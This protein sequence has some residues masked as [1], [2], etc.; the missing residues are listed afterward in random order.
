[1]EAW[2]FDELQKVVVSVEHLR[3]RRGVL[4]QQVTTVH[5]LMHR[6]PA[7]TTAL[8]DDLLFHT[9]AYATAVEGEAV[10]QFMMD[11]GARRSP[12]SFMYLLA[13]HQL[14]DEI[15]ALHN[16]GVQHLDQ[17]YHTYV[18]GNFIRLIR[19]MHLE[20]VECVRRFYVLCEKVLLMYSSFHRS[21]VEI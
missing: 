20:T 11:S 17:L 1:M 16:L 9:F 18:A 13:H 10:W 19:R 8:P 2:L 6:I 3:V 7:S 14:A 5:Q 21:P 12:Y 15:I 4:Y